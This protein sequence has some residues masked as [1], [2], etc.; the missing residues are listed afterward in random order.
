MSS[1]PSVTP[2]ATESKFKMNMGRLLC[3]G[4]EKNSKAMPIGMRMEAPIAPM[5]SKVSEGSIIAM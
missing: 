5:V 2:N 4:V 1:A 3:T